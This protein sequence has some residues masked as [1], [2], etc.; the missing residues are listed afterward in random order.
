MRVPAACF[1]KVAKYQMRGHQG[2]MR[3]GGAYGKSKV[4]SDEEDGELEV[5]GVVQVVVVDDN[6]GGEHDPDRDDGRGR[7]LLLRLWLI[8]GRWRG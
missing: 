3:G 8:R 1:R 2:T 4:E 7:Q 5:S 6:R